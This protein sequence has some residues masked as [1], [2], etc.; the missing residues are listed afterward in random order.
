L[1][2]GA[3]VFAAAVRG[4]D[5]PGKK[6]KSEHPGEKSGHGSSPL[7]QKRLIWAG[8][9]PQKSDAENSIGEVKVSQIHR[10]RVGRFDSI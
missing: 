7:F 10:S 2:I 4:I 9:N 3:A 5:A 1:P 8:V 6:A